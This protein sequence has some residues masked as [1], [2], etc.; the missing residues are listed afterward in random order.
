[1]G[2]WAVREEEKRFDGGHS[3]SGR[4]LNMVYKKG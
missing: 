2:G 4:R 1:M 3:V